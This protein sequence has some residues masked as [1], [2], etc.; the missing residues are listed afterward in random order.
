LLEVIDSELKITVKQGSSIKEL[1]F[2]INDAVSVICLSIRGKITN[3]ELLEVV[4]KFA[5]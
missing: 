2:I 4:A 1:I 5:D 3:E